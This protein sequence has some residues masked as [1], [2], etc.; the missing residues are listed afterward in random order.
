MFA[1]INPTEESQIAG[2]YLG[3]VVPENGQWQ[4]LL[5]TVKTR[6]EYHSSHTRAYQRL[7]LQY[8]GIAHLRSANIQW[9]INHPDYPRYSY[10]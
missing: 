6:S 2:L 4:P 5:K 10:N 1:K 7:A 8:Q 3:W 9:R